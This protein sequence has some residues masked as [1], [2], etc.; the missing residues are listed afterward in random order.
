[1]RHAEALESGSET[2]HTVSERVIQA[3]ADREGVSPLDI[4][5]PLFDAVDPDALNRMFGADSDDR[6]VFCLTVEG[7]NVFVRGDG[8]VIVGDPER[9]IE[10][11][12]LF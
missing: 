8:T 7:W 2:T 4:S 1:M 9:K 10:A 3:V 5:P 11:T 12:P 6:K